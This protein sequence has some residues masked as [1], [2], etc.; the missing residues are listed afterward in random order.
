[1]NG[2]CLC[3]HV[4]FDI[5]GPLLGKA[6][7]C[8]CTQCRKQSGH[9]WAS[10]NVATDDLQVLGDVTWYEATNA[11]KRG[12]CARCGSML[13]WKA[14]DEDQISFSL[15]CLDDEGGIRL[16]RHIFTADKGDYYD[17]TDGLPQS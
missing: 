13:F 9:H 14:H 7:A 4:R 11:A 6:S 1:M 17:I 5:T 10:A 16:Q 3:G 15:G 8:H 12:F 2:S